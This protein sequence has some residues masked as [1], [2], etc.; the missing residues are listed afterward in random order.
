MAG[1]VERHL[2]GR[3]ANGRMAP[4]KRA[5]LASDPPVSTGNFFARALRNCDQ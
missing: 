1:A 4:L 5:Y 2:R 3:N